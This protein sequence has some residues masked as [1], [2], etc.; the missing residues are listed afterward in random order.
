M[1]VELMVYPAHSRLLPYAALFCLTFALTLG[2]ILARPIESLSLFWP[3]NAVLA[4]VLLR[5]PRQANLVGFA[6]IW[7]AMVTADI[8]SGSAWTPAL[9]F[10]LCNL[11][12]VVTVW[13]LLSRLPRVHW[14]MRTP[15][16]VLCLFGACA[17]GAVVAASM[18]SAMATP[19]FEQSLRSTW[20]AWFSEQ[21]ST[22]ILVLPV[23][24]TAP[25]ARALPRSRTHAIR[26]AP[27]LVLLASLAL[28][29]G[30]GGPGAIAFPIAAL[31]WCA[32]TYSPFLV[33]LLALTAGSTLIVAVAQN[34]MHFSLPQ[35]ELGVTTLMSARLGIAMLVLGPLVVAC[36]SQA[37]RSLL[38]RLAHQATIDHL[39]GVLT[40]SA[41]TR[42]ANALLEGRQ[43]H[44]QALPLTLMMLDIDHFKSIN[45]RHGHGVG[46]EV[47]R[48]FART[49]QDQL[50]EGELLARM[51][52]EEFVVIVP[53][54]APDRARFTAERLRRAVQDL[55]VVK[56]D[57]RLQI[58]VSIGL[59]GCAADAPAPSLDE[60]LARADLA[61]YRAKAHGRNRVE[62]AEPL[63]DQG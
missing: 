38:A 58:T 60:L 30:F 43:Q 34:L 54:L 63:R 52:G 41:F 23:L 4:G 18:A 35:S 51:G 1:P 16:G 32:W 42:R 29:I 33:S 12:V 11:G 61:L 19:W 6:L 50:H 17:A 37:N 36:V 15:H 47:L 27:L 21:F 8:A 49:L 62:Q 39:T 31:L 28:S 46:D 20:L 13:R 7:V 25:S 22:S 59:D 14:R 3:V 53:G 5:N 45:D 10:N 57:V 44:A 48:Q 2:G 56:A 40:R 26:L 55:H 9:W 24:L